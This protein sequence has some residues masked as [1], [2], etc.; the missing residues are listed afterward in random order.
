[1]LRI[2]VKNLKIKIIELIQNLSYKQ[3][4]HKIEIKKFLVQNIQTMKSSQLQES[5][6]DMDVSGLQNMN[7]NLR[8]QILNKNENQEMVDAVDDI[9]ERLIMII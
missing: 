3:H 8:Q 5:L 1:M 9:K 7:L 6:M 2:A 4:L